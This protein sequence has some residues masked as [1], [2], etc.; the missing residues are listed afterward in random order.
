MVCNEDPDVYVQPLVE[1]GPLL[2]G[3]TP[4]LKTQ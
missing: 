2:C 4:Y 3:N 1:T